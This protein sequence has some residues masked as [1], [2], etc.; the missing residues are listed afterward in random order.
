MESILSVVAP[1]P[2]EDQARQRGQALALAALAALQVAVKEHL[3]AL[4]LRKPV[5]PVPVSHNPCRTRRLTF[6]DHR[7]RCLLMLH[8]C[9]RCLWTACSQ[10]K[11]QRRYSQCRVMR[12]GCHPPLQFLNRL[13]I[14]LAHISCPL[15][16]RCFVMAFAAG[17]KPARLCRFGV[18]P[19]LASSRAS[20]KD[21]LNKQFASF[22]APWAPE[23]GWRA[24]LNVSAL[25]ARTRLAWSPRQL[26]CMKSLG[27]IL[28]CSFDSCS[29]WMLTELAKGFVFEVALNSQGN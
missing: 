21:G 14:V 6:Y 20:Y 19:S 16:S 22:R 10:L 7:L 25:A 13:R 17:S 26:N 1:M 23:P 24:R 8:P 4:E 29:P 5:Q 18:V 9:H 28:E 11:L 15:L 12:A 2:A 27:E 3:E